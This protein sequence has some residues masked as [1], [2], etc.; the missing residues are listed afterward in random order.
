[1]DCEITLKNYRCFSDEKPARFVLQDG[2]T[3][4]IGANNS[5]KSTILKFFWEFRNLFAVHTQEA[6]QFVAPLGSQTPFNMATSVAD[7]KELFHKWN[8][9]DISIYLKPLKMDNASVPDGLVVRAKRGSNTY[10]LQFVHQGNPIQV[11]AERIH[12]EG[13]ST[14]RLHKSVFEIR[15]YIDLFRD[16]HST[17]YLGSSRNAINVGGTEPYFDISVAQGFFQI[18]RSWKTGNSIDQNEAIDRLTEDIRRIFEFKKLEIDA[19]QDLRTLKFMIN[20]RSFTLGELGTGVAQ[21]ALVLGNLATR[22]PAPAFVLIDEPEINLHPTLQLDFLTTLGHYARRGVYYSTHS[23]GLARARAPQIHTL[24]YCPDAGSEMRLLESTPRLSELLGELSYSSYRE[25]GFEKVLLV[26]G[27]TEVPAIQQILRH[28]QKDHTILLLP[29]G[30]SSMINGKRSHE[31]EE[32]KRITPQIWALIDSERASAG[33]QLE[34]SRGDF[35]KACSNAGINTHV[36]GL[37]ALENYLTD[38]AVKAV[39]GP[40]YKALGPFEKLESASPSWSKSD[41]WRI[42]GRMNRADWDQSD[43]GKFLGAL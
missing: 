24:R 7:P 31:L 16:L 1:M 3:A 14:L 11:N 5:G 42:A 27:V 19:S 28:Y 37:R 36:L 15:P 20:G 4:F 6:Q 21:F 18:W 23:Y 40:K 41:N 30:G 13:P 22:Q 34:Q 2:F 39:M 10:S 17:L 35:V 9:R 26:E 32:I 12:V 43:L 38:A 33:D 8:D 25:L 29:L